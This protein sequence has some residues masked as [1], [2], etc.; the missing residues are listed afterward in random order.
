MTTNYSQHSLT[1]KKGYPDGEELNLA[2]IFDGSYT[3]VTVASNYDGDGIYVVGNSKNNSL[4]GSK[5][6]DT[7]EAGEGKNTL[8][9]GSGDDVFVHSGGKDLITDYKAGDKIVFSDDNEAESWQVK[10]GNVIFTTENG[11][12]TVKGG[13]GK[14]I[15]IENDGDEF[16]VKYKSGKGAVESSVSDLWFDDDEFVTDS[17]SVSD[18]VADSNYSVAEVES[19]DTTTVNKN[20]VVTFTGK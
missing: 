8:T 19:A 20:N 4:V 12:V 7:L 9:G 14:S 11:S 2:D 5:S 17:A 15:T 18:I 13:K 16:T 6:D 1:V 10:N 3:K